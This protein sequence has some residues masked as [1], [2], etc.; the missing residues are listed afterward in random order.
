[1]K[2]LSTSHSFLNSSFSCAWLASYH[3][4]TAQ[5][6]LA[7]NTASVPLL[8][9]IVS[10]CGRVPY[11]PLYTNPQHHD[12]LYIYA[13]S[14]IPFT[15]H[16][17]PQSLPQLILR[18]PKHQPA[19]FTHEVPATQLSA[20]LIRLGAPHQR[21]FSR[22]VVKNLKQGREGSWAIQLPAPNS[23]LSFCSKR[24]EE[25]SI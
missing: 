24:K 18:S 14:S 5:L 2:I 1:M 9:P 6:T 21:N 10:R 13:L 7:N 15:F 8:Y 3:L 17:S 22:N 23:S 12:H 11:K 16:Y 19:M 4:L 20:A 25:R